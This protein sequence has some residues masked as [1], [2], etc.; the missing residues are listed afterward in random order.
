MK[1]VPEHS[2]AVADE[3]E[4]CCALDGTLGSVAGVLETELTLD[5]MESD[6]ERPALGVGLDDLAWRQLRVGRD[7][8]ATDLLGDRFAALGVQIGDD[9][10]GADDLQHQA[11]DP[12][13]RQEQQ[14]E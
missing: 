3:S 6:L 10:G 2:E 9:D 7:E 5:L 13:D 11:S 4:R 8:D 1:D 14:R 12:D